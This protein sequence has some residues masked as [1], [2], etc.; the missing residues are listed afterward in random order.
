MTLNDP[1]LT[2]AV[3]VDEPNVAADAT[4]A[5]TFA[6]LGLPQTLVTAL[7]RRGIRTPFAIQASALPDA[8]TG[9]DV[10]GKAATGSVPTSAAAPVPHAGWFSCPPA[11]WPSR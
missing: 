4:P 10:L 2:P 9:R 3:P 1:A 7:E 11:S 8:L 6:A 5:P